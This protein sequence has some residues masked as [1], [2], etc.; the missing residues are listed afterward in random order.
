MINGVLMG[1]TTVCISMVGGKT[2]PLNND[3][4][5]NS[6]DDDIPNMMGKS[7]NMFQTTNQITIIFPLLLVYSLWKQLLTII[8]HVMNHPT[9]QSCSSHH[10]PVV[11][12][13]PPGHA[14][15]TRSPSK[16]LVVL[17]GRH[18]SQ[19]AIRRVVA[20]THLRKGRGVDWLP[21]VK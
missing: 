5:S 4:V 13:L 19:V 10:Q 15:P 6:W 16:D 14:G 9:I 8:N 11:G 7:K 2:T 17:A 12:T 20:P 18:R 1:W 3:G 21:G